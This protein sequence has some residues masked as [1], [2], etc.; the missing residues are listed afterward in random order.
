MS[1]ENVVVVGAGIVG[2]CCAIV[3]R[4]RGL[5]VQ[6]IDRK[7]PA[8]ETSYGN[9]GVICNSYLLPQAKPSLRSKLPAMLL[10]RDPRFLIHYP[11]LAS[12]VP[13][14]G[15]FAAYCNRKTMESRV[16]ALSHLLAG[17]IEE[18]IDFMRQSGA[19]QYLN[20]SGWL[21]LYR[22]Q[23]SYGHS[24][25]ERSYYDKYGV[26]YQTL[27]WDGIQQLEPDLRVRYERGIWLDKLPSVRNPGAVCQRYA[28]YF[29][30][31]GGII[32]RS[33]IKHL[34]RTSSG[35]TVHCETQA[36]RAGQVV[37]AL[38]AWSPQLLGIDSFNNPIAIERGYHM[39]FRPADGADL[40]RS[41]MDVDRGFVM[42][43]MEQGIRATSATN[44]TAR[45]TAPTYTQMIDLIPRIR[46][47]FP[48]GKQLLSEPWMGRRPS[49]ADS[50]PIIGPAKLHPGLWY[51]FGHGHLGFTLGP[52]TGR[53]IGNAVA[54]D[55]WDPRN[56]PFLPSRFTLREQ[57]Y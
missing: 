55:P 25:L 54:G 36:H 22:D 33:E 45:E 32:V 40:R 5:S 1:T 23:P 21:R 48:V 44:L 6:L 28:Q 57:I 43:P 2:I 20:N 4:Q 50:L 53:I 29:R 56:D 42:T 15:R 8:E 12:L 9:S 41:I 30:S 37:V 52:V 34:A 17:A 18:H 39:M 11:H 46:E 10:N 26:S 13:W 38:G 19:N 16:P 7:G 14:L 27:D 24:E 35:W 51:A 49:T 47:T 3:L 31:L